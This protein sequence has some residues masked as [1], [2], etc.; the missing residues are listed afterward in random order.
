MG[1]KHVLLK[2]QNALRF[3][4]NSIIILYIFDIKIKT[5]IEPSSCFAVHL[6]EAGMER[7]KKVSGKK[8]KWLGV[9]LKLP[10]IPPSHSSPLP[11]HL[12]LSHHSYLSPH[13]NLSPHP[14]PPTP[15]S[16]QTPLLPSSC[17][18]SEKSQCILV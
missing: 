9:S 14:P 13:L 11:T 18:F 7:R 3:Y 16:H 4:R 10:L 12:H 5:R 8:V 1:C 17:E 2:P 6:L 15:F